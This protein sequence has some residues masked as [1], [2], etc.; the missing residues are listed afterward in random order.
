MS[1]KSIPEKLYFMHTRASNGNRLIGNNV[2]GFIEI[3]SICDGKNGRPAM[4]ATAREIVN[5]Y[6]LH[7]D[8]LEVCKEAR[9]YLRFN[10]GNAS[11]IFDK[12]EEIITKTKWR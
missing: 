3:D 1:K 4:N 5:R 7:S 11:P 2:Y 9:D 12:L 8:L 10:K 6:N